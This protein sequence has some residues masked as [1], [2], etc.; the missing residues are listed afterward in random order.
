MATEVRRLWKRDSQFFKAYR[1][2]SFTDSEHI[3]ETVHIDLTKED[4]APTVTDHGD[5]TIGIHDIIKWG[6]LRLT[7]VQA[8]AL[9]IRINNILYRGEV[10]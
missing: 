5:D 8:A 4:L 7:K 3:K 10:R 1:G 9:A 6:S 2:K